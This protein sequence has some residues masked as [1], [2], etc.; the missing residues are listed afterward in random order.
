[1]KNKK[2]SKQNFFKELLKIPLSAKII[3]GTVILLA[4][5]ACILIAINTK[6][7]FSILLLEIVFCIIAHFY[8]ENYTIKNSGTD[9][10][11]YILRSENTYKWLK[12]IDIVLT[13]ENIKDILQRTKFT[14]KMMEDKRNETIKRIEKWIQVLL[15]P[16]FISALSNFI[17]KTTDVETIVYSS[18]V[19]ILVF[20]MIIMLIVCIFNV[21]DF[22]K[23]RKLEQ[24][25]YFADD[26]Q[27]VLDC[28]LENKILKQHKNKKI[29][30]VI[31][32][33]QKQ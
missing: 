32:L 1:M 19:I 6:L 22:Y 29:V 30:Y 15:I 7:Y 21:F 9:L 13:N 26:L 18:F 2:E 5:S 31:S 8:T 10:E 16:L 12:S 33:K 28:Q 20:T 17:G 14:I 4:I 23:K 25:K 27:G 24:Y 11:K 3:L